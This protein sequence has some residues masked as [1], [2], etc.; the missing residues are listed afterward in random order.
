MNDTYIIMIM[1]S[2]LPLYVYVIWRAWQFR[3]AVVIIPSFWL[4]AVGVTSMATAI[5]NSFH[6]VIVRNLLG[7]SVALCLFMLA[8]S[9][10]KLTL[11]SK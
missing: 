11:E 5:A 6:G 2:R 9:A 7:Y 1:L 3:R 10:K 4:G 8:H